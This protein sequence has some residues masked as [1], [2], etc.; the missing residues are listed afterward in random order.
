MSAVPMPSTFPRRG[1]FSDDPDTY[2]ESIRAVCAVRDSWLDLGLRVGPS[3][4]STAES[5][6]AQLYRRVEYEE[7]EFVWV[8]SPAAATTFVNAEGLATE[9]PVPGATIDH[10]PARIASLLADSRRRMDQRIDGRRI[11]WPRQRF[12]PDGN[13]DRDLPARITAANSPPE[14]A[15]RAG[16]SPDPIV[17]RTVWNSLRTSLFDGV[18]SA[19]RQLA[20]HSFGS[21]TWYGQQ[22]AH[23]VAFYDIHRRFGLTT[24]SAGHV[25]LLELQRDLVESTGWWWAFEN[26]AVMCERPT[27]LQT[28]PIP[29]SFHGEVRL[30]NSRA[31]ALEFSDGHAVNV[32]HGTVVPD[33]VMHDPTVER[34]T[35]ERNVEVRRCA[36]ERIGWDTYLD[37]A[38]LALLDTA[39]DPG[40][41]G[42]TLH[43]FA[44]PAGWGGDGRVLL[45]V[46]GSRERDGDRRRYGLRIPGEI[47]SALDAAAWTY[48]LSGTDYV[49]LLR[50][51]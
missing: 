22:E 47:S 11:E 9:T 30:H 1:T 48:G 16:I 27:T 29:D 26:V 12:R 49:Q 17:R 5:A 36:I 2:S 7:P 18:A 4:R 51:T 42:C 8:T 25:E 45:A 38:G 20:P 14:D 28:E 35:T 44:T 50:R 32:L 13:F 10:A 37:Q 6:V 46:N 24:F 23:R 39:D 19:I 21:I 34:I 15:A 33:W 40:N 43:L 41:P 31:P 3:D